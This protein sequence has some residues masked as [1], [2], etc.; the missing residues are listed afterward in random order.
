M[1][2]GQS[3]RFQTWSLILQGGMQ[4]GLLSCLWLPPYRLLERVFREV[5]EEL[6]AVRRMAPGDSRRYG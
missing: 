4:T 3:T 5:K 2:P 6:R 1:L